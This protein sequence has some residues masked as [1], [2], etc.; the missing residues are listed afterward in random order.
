METGDVPPAEVIG[1]LRKSVAVMLPRLNSRGEGFEYGRSLGPY[2]E[3][4][5][6]E[7]MTAAAV[8]NLL[9]D[10]DKALAYAYASRAAL[11][12]ADFWLDAH[13]GSVNLWDQGRRTDTY[14]GKFRILGENFSLGHQYVYTNA[15]W[16]RMGYRNKPP[17]QDFAAKLERLPDR[18][19]TWFARG[20]YDRML[21]TLREGDRVI[22]LPLINGGGV[23][24]HARAVLSDSVLA[25]NARRRCGRNG[26]VPAAAIRAR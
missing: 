20:K 13:T 1:W 3:T 5:I 4:A 16:N 23:S 7:V 21:L 8:L 24:A 2:G 26:A 12:Y 15:A 10:D 11:R 22:G 14:R 17:L 18:S 9:N 25:G 6:I 19:T